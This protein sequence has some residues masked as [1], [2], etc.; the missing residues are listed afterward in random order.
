M[1]DCLGRHAGPANVPCLHPHRLGYI[2]WL[3]Y[4]WGAMMINQYEGSDVKIF[5]DVGVLDY[6]SLNGVSKWA[7]LG[8][9]SLT[10]VFFFV[11]CYMVSHPHLYL[12]N[13]DVR[14]PLVVG[15]CTPL[16]CL[17]TG[18]STQGA[19]AHECVGL[20]CCRHWY[21]CDTRSGDASY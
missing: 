3:W 1:R 11:V 18:C 8:Y 14:H 17:D 21:S 13:K 12:S 7:F 9:S 10:F 5:G 19:Y 20:F 2:N 16:R 4:G 6:Y 15:W